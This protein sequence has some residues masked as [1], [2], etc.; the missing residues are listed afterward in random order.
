MMEF[1]A[2]NDPG[3]SLHHQLQQQR[4]YSLAYDSQTAYLPPAQTPP[5][6]FSQSL[7]V[8]VERQ[9][10][11]IDRFIALQ[12]ER[13]RVALQEQ[14]KQQLIALMRRVEARTMVLLRQKEEDIAKACR[15]TEELEEY[16]RRI[17]AENQ[18]W[19]RIA[20]ENEAMVLSLNNT[21]EQ[22]MRENLCL[23]SGGA[24]D[25]ESCCDFS[26]ESSP[27]IKREEEGAGGEDGR[28]KKMAC[29]ACNS[30][31]SCVL[32]LP[33]RHL[34]SCKHCETS[35]DSCPVCKSVKKAS[36]EVYML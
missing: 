26:G 17:E 32:I 27:S 2:W 30:R 35:L 9:R 19:Q 15:K 20:R 6:S 12:N 23:F 3:P 5:M 4:N 11:E 36:I 29:K 13:L 22:M 16:L 25:A 33:C 21:L 10:Q 28:R 7:A 18:T 34:C 14:R 8:H 24:E 31:D 1:G